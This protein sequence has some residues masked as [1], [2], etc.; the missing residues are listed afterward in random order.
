MSNERMKL[1]VSIAVLVGSLTLL[2]FQVRSHVGKKRAAAPAA[3]EDTG[4]MMEYSARVASVAAVR[5]S[6]PAGGLEEALRANPFLGSA[7]G[8]SGASG[9]QSASGGSAERVRMGLDLQGVRTGANPMAIINDRTVEIG[10]TIAGWQ[11]VSVDRHRVTLRKSDGTTIQLK[12]PR[13][14]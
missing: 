12:P 4:M 13:A 8:S 7:V 5:W 14:G 9:A 11:V 10:E 1:V 6:V 2:G 3:S